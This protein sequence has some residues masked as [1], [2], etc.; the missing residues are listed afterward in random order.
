MVYDIKLR[1]LSFTFLNVDPIV[2]ILNLVLEKTLE[3][4]LDSKG[5]KPVNPRGNQP[6]IYI[7]STDAEAEAPISWPP[8]AKRQHIGKDPDTGK[9]WGQAEKGVTE[10]EM[11]GW[12]HSLSGHEFEQTL[13]D[14]EGQG[15]LACCS[16][17]GP[18]ELDTTDWLN[19][20]FQTSESGYRGNISQH[21]KSHLWCTRG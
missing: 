18:K 15:S 1:K 19:N 2:Q 16:L 9:D 17:W 20:N 7:G 10:G 8:N 3:S 6:W 11:F 5:M 14:S 4:P 12:H 13:R 21:N